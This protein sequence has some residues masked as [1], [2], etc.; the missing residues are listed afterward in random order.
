MLQKT[1]DPAVLLMRASMRLVEVFEAMDAKPPSG[2]GCPPW[3]QELVLEM[4][5]P[6]LM[7]HRIRFW[8]ERSLRC[9]EHLARCC[10]KHYGVTLTELLNRARIERAK[11]R[12]GSG[13]VKLAGV[14]YEVGFHN[15][16][17]F[18]RVFRQTQGC[19]PGQWLT[20]LKCSTIPK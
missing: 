2:N 12:L 1:P 14:A 5:H 10:R 4:N 16:G 8:Q 13:D 7:V 9:P 20:K 15:L 18:Y 17:Y 19:T 6:D 3:L 11:F